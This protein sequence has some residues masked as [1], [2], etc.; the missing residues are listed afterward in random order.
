MSDIESEA[1]EKPQFPKGNIDQR[2]VF[3][4]CY[5]L[6]GELFLEPAMS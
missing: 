6:C 5:I 2:K 4:T 3:E 1:T